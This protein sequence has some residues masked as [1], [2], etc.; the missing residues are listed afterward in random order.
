M[1]VCVEVG[2]N[3]KTAA[4][5][6]QETGCCW[7]DILKEMIALHWTTILLSFIK[8]GRFFRYFTVCEVVGPDRTAP[9]AQIPIKCC[10]CWSHGRDDRDVAPKCKN[11]EAARSPRARRSS[12]QGNVT[13]SLSPSKLNKTCHRGWMFRLIFCFLC[14]LSPTRRS[15]STRVRLRVSIGV[16]GDSVSTRGRGGPRPCFPLTLQNSIWCLERT[17]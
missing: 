13:I 5:T 16:I 10:V 9:L 2:T 1:C 12:P 15:N 3:D 11:V 7:A 8:S 14:H 6:P 4:S 17:H